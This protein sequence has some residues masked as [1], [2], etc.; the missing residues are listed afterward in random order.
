MSYVIRREELPAAVLALDEI[1]FPEDYR[2]STEGALWWVVWCGKQPVG[3]AGLRPCMAEVN[4]GLGFLNRAGVVKGHR[5]KGLQKRL[6]RVR[7][8]GAR[9]AGLRELVTYVASW[10]CASINSLIGCG[11]KT[12]S[13][14]INWGGTG[15]VYFWKK[16]TKKGK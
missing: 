3:Y 4:S 15:A 1:C 7:E 9:A 6:I 2:I 14:E 16:L 12:Y 13:P 8:A 5:G 10:T 11:Y